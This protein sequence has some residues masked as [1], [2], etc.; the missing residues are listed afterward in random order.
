LAYVLYTSGSTGR[1]KGVMIEHRGLLNHACWFSAEFGLSAD[2]VSLQRTTLA[3]DAAGVEIW[4]TLIVGARLVIADDDQA[5][6]P[7]ALLALSHAEAV[8]FM[9]AVP[10]QIGAMVDEFERHPPSQGSSLRA[11]FVGGDVLSPQDARQWY[12]HTGIAL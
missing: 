2:D 10:G 12:R 9:Q 5:R 11:V 4:P 3:F 7:R 8:S 1:P 6:D